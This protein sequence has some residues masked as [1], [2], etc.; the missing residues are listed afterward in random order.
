[1]RK[2]VKC[3]KCGIYFR[4]KPWSEPEIYKH[5]CFYCSFIWHSL[6]S[7]FAGLDMVLKERGAKRRVWLDIKD[8]KIEKFK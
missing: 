5:L 8:L 6:S 4:E 2:R 1:M 7:V 3:E